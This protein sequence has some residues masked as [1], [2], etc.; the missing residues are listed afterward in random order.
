MVGKSLGHYEILEPLGAGGMGEVYRARDTHLDRDVAIKVLPED[1]A[2]DQDRLARFEREAKLLASLNHANI[3]TIHGLEDADGVRFIA[4]ELVE[5]ETLADRLAASGRIEV[6]KALEIA[7]QIAEAL[8]AAHENGVI[9]RDLK[10]ANVKVT[11]DGKVKVLDFGL[12]K[13]YGAEG[14]AAE[15]S[16]DLSHSPTKAG[17][18]RAGVILGTAAYMSPEQARGKPLDRRTD[19]WSFGCVLYELLTGRPPFG[20]E[21]VS[22]TI[23][24]ILERDPR[25]SD[26]PRTTPVR[27][28]ELLRRCLE[29][30]S[31]RRLR[32]IG[33]AW[34]EIEETL[35]VPEDD[36]VFAAVG[37][38]GAGRSSRLW[39]GIMAA[40]IVVSVAAGAM[41]TRWMT[42]SGGA[43]SPRRFSFSLPAE[44][45]LMLGGR[46]SNSSERPAI[47]VSPDGTRLV[48]VAA[49]GEMTALYVATV[50]EF[51]ATRLAGTEGAA[52]PFFSPDG[53]WIA[54]FTADELKRVSL[55]GGTPETLCRVG[56]SFGGAWTGDTVYF[57]AESGSTLMRV[58]ASGGTPRE[59]S[60]ADSIGV[61]GFRYPSALPDGRGLLVTAWTLA[62]MSGD[63]RDIMVLSFDSGQWET[64]LRSA[65]Y[66]V[67]YAPSGHLVY[68][69]GGGLR[70]A[71]FDLER[72]EVTGDPAPVL[73]G[74]RMYSL[75]DNAQFDF[76]S[77]GTLVYAVGG[78]FAVGVPAWVDSDGGVEEL[79]MPAQAYGFFQ[80]SPDGDRLAIQ[81]A[82]PTDSVWIYD[83]ATGDRRKLTV[84]GDGGWPLW[85]HDGR[86]VAFSSTRGGRWGLYSKPAD[87]S[88]EVTL[89]YESDSSIFP[90]SWSAQHSLVVFGL[91]PQF[92]PTLV[93][94]D[95]GRDPEV[96]PY[97]E[98][99][100]VEWGHQISADGR[101][102]AYTSNREGPFGLYV[103]RYPE[104]DAGQKIIADAGAWEGV[105]SRQGDKIFFWNADQWMVVDVPADG[106]FAGQRPRRLF[107]TSL[108]DTFGISYDVAPDGR[109]LL[110]KPSDDGSDPTRLDIVLNWFEELERLVPT[111]Q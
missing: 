48:Y 13:A 96:V 71:P 69:R 2:T 15:S 91:G 28:R 24:A 66:Y 9:H 7:R 70:A 106:D 67:R 45:S 58:P 72:L 21:T 59:V 19:I 86:R 105:W 109:I 3:A 93:W 37:A 41:V 64:V 52:S 43:T 78:D 16:P 60:R 4:M 49:E 14:S 89:L 35:A 104:L 12:A 68:A 5:G 20:G 99:D 90:F 30:E 95:E 101:W 57:V 23:A 102:I 54:F 31:R 53:Q 76:S 10:P 98:T 27:I 36:R 82:G 17:A 75:F 63:Y 92:K 55:L 33:D 97:P 77:N 40:A 85:T 47:T 56:F 107:Q 108:V 100:F 94:F 62:P 46:T 110:I 34:L 83:V 50:G 61:G 84:E 39:A 74:V 18:T 79:N 65:G 42:Q 32:D 111:N 26:L 29:K 6:N 73:D 38:G 22:D 8:E 11:L 51:G 25:W 80:L 1:F 87:G 88:D 81:V 103:R 44:A